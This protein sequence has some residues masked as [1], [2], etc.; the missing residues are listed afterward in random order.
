MKEDYAAKM[1]LKTNAALREYV[2]GHY[3]YREEA[4]LA[5][6]DELRARGLPAPEEG[7]LR[8]ALETAAVARSQAE[9]ALRVESAP[10]VSADPDAED[11][12]TGPAL[13]SPLV[14]I[15]FSMLSVVIGGVLMGLNLYRVGKKQAVLM[16]VLFTIVY[17]LI[18]SAVINWASRLGPMAL[19]GSVF[20]FNLTTALVYIRWFWQRHIG[21]G[22]Y[23]SR[24]VLVPVLVCML[25]IWGAQRLTPYLLQNQPKQNRQQLE[26]L[27]HR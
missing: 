2:I 10:A 27:L 20:F 26:Q 24:G 25:L 18:G 7:A 9:A 19:L 22:N 12:A 23:R 16:L 3:Q 21:A 4:V 5:A 11:A 17:L 14:I 8:P 15:A 6:F 1:A 13:Y